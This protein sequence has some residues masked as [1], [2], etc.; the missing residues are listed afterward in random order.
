MLQ[1]LC[2][3]SKLDFYCDL[4]NP[5]LSLDNNVDI[6]WTHITTSDNAFF[7]SSA[8]VVKWYGKQDM[9]KTRLGSRL[10]R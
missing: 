9:V 10:K 3:E 2:Q 6:G 4:L 8:N 1:L 5:G 7:I